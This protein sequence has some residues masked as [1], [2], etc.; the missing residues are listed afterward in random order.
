M[1]A[2]QGLKL[3]ENAVQGGLFWF[4]M[5]TLRDPTPGGKRN[6]E[7]QK[8]ESATRFDISFLLLSIVHVPR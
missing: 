8:A 6:L 2:A 4:V 7:K 5:E 1:G 3:L